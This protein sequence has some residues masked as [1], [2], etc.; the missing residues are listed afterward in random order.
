MIRGNPHPPAP[1]PA[2][3]CLRDPKKREGEQKLDGMSMESGV[4]P[5]LEVKNLKTYLVYP[6]PGPSPKHQGGERMERSLNDWQKS[7]WWQRKY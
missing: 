5:I 1:S 4:E 7:T 2:G 3:Q 6:S